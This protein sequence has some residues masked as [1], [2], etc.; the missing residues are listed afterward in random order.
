MNE[1]GEYLKQLRGKRSLREMERITGLSHTYLSTLEKGYD[2]RSKKPRHPTPEVL[3]K[4]S[5]TLNVDYEQLLEKAGYIDRTPAIGIFNELINSI[6]ENS[7]LSEQLADQLFTNMNFAANNKLDP[8]LIE[9]LNKQVKEVI[10][11]EQ[12]TRNITNNFI[13]RMA[14]RDLTTI[15]HNVLD[16]NFSD[17][18][19]ELDLKYT[20]VFEISAVE[21]AKTKNEKGLLQKIPEHKALEN[22][23]SIENLLSLSDLVNYNGIKLTK[24]HKEKI[25]RKIN[26]IVRVN[27]Q[28]AYRNDEMKVD[29]TNNKQ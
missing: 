1:F 14:R 17:K 4:V 7:Q 20:V 13:K 3:K 2:P 25:T 29:I 21:K 5:E 27:E 18:K 24:V 26:E 19:N 12:N 28:I 6:E 9:S 22:F 8:Q 11:I 23:Y 15:E 16:T 10:Q